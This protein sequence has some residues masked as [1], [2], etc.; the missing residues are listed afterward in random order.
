MTI[1]FFRRSA[2]EHTTSR[3]GSGY[4]KDDQQ[5][6]RTEDYCTGQSWM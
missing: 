5:L 4:E 3:I 6:E 2:E 1:I